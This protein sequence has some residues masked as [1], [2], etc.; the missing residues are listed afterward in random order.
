MSEYLHLVGQKFGLVT[1]TEHDH[2]R[3]WVGKCECGMFRIFNATNLRHAPP[4]SHRFCHRGWTQEQNDEGKT[5]RSRRHAVERDLAR[6]AIVQAKARRREEDQERRWKEAETQIFEA[7]CE[8][9]YRETEARAKAREAVATRRQQQPGRS[10]DRV[11]RQDH[12]AH[13]EGLAE[14][15]ERAGGEKGAITG[16]VHA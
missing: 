14:D 8:E 3:Y 6:A 12:A 16:R 4:S 11:P 7:L 13:A 5:I 1:V 10:P 15:A 2:G 9:G